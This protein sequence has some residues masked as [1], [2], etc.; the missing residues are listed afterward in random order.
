[1][2]EAAPAD[3]SP[4]P[5]PFLHTIRVAWSDCDPARIAYTAR[6]PFFAL[7]A[8][9]AWWDH[10]TGFDWY[11]LNVD[12][13]IGTP[14]VHMTLDFS[15]PVTPRHRLICEVR[16]LKI[17]STS[18]RFAVHGRQDGLLCFQGEFVSAFVVGDKMKPRRP[19]DDLLSAIR[20]L[21]VN[22]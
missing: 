19:P 11:K 8:I 5:A 14:F 16:L 6:I 10:H 9:D 13:N 2:T 22:P 12:R 3:A 1:M 7:D 20:P 15:A 18:I 21:V 17:G 4:D